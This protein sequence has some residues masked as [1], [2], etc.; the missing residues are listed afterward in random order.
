MKS[1]SVL[2]LFL[3]VTGCASLRSIDLVENNT[4]E[5]AAEN[6]QKV[7]VKIIH[8]KQVED[9]VYVDGRVSRNNDN[10]FTKGYVTVD[11][12]DE[13][14]VRIDSTDAEIS[15]RRSG[16]RVLRGGTFSVQ[17]EE[18]PAKHSKVVVTAH[19]KRK[20]S[21]SGNGSIKIM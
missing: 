1:L 20:S 11:L 14:G 3:F 16:P 15:F 2:L 7:N 4:T 13:R 9:A 17:L 10:R 8:V 18:K 5:V 6:S 21:D 12:Y 19:D